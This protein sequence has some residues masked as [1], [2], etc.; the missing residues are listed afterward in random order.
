MPSIEV[1]ER[2][3]AEFDPIWRRKVREMG[4]YQLSAEEIKQVIGAKVHPD[5]R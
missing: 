3:L 2:M 1:Y 4:D 5:H